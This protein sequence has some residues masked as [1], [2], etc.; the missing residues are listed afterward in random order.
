MRFRRQPTHDLFVQDDE[1]PDV[2]EE[3]EEPVYKWV[4]WF[5]V[6]GEADRFADWTFHDY[7]R[8]QAAVDKLISAD[9]DELITYERTDG[10]ISTGIRAGDVIYFKLVRQEHA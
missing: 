9:T 7:G 1:D 4:L 3:P 8:A 6:R 2:P 5:W 10:T